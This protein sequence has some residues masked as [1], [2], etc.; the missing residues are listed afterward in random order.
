MASAVL[1][2]VATAV[3]IASVL[4]IVSSTQWAGIARANDDDIGTVLSGYRQEG[5]EEAKEVL[6]QRIGNLAGEMPSTGQTYMR[7]QGPDAQHSLGNLPA[8]PEVIGTFDMSWFPRTRELRRGHAVGSSDGIAITGRGIKLDDSYYLFVGRDTA[9]LEMTRARIL[10]ASLWIMLGSIAAASIG[11][12]LLA[13]RLIRRVDDITLTC[14]GIIAGRFE[15]RINTVGMGS[16]WARLAGA[17]NGMLNRISS[18]L[19]SLQQVSNDIAHDLRSPL[20]RLRQ[21]LEIARTSHAT[22]TDHRAVLDHAIEDTD[23]ILALF[24]ALL[25]IAQIEAGTRTASFEPVDLA[26]LL[27]EVHLLYQ[28]LTEDSG[29]SIE[30]ETASKIFVMGDR[31]LLFQMSSNLVEN[32]IRHTPEG[33]QI[34][35]RLRRVA[36]RARIEVTDNGPG[37]PDAELRH[38]TRRFYRLERSRSTPGHGLGLALVDAV[39]RLHGSRLVLTNANPGLVACVEFDMGGTA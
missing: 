23:Q 9:T 22:R 18:L 14:E 29:R 21:R 11:G 15:E 6:R 31:E 38:V 25:R 19:E 35:L 12:V 26:E 32:A 24:G 36:G 5:I 16:E 30:C 10:K 27:R 8:V 4:W 7:I 20:T 28:P 34:K 1:F 2:V 3:L 17:I 33:S 37:I 39:A 13:T